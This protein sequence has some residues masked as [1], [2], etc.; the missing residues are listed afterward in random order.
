MKCLGLAQMFLLLCLFL[1]LAFMVIMHATDSTSHLSADTGAEEAGLLY[2]VAPAVVAVIV[3]AVA[4]SGVAVP[5]EVVLVPQWRW[6]LGV[7]SEDLLQEAGAHQLQGPRTPN[8]QGRR[9]KTNPGH[10]Q[11]VQM[12]R[13]GAW[14]L[15]VMVPRTLIER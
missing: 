5:S 12:R 6:L 9:A 7:R 8:L 15:M 14:F 10:R 11:K 2:H 1:L 3:G 13:K 4:P